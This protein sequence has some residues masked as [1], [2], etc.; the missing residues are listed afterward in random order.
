MTEQDSS[1]IKTLY[2]LNQEFYNNESIF[3]INNTIIRYKSY[4][5]D[6]DLI[7]QMKNSISFDKY[8]DL[9]KNNITYEKFKQN[10]DKNEQINIQK[11]SKINQYSNSKDL[12]QA[13][14][15]NKKFYIVTNSLFK[16]IIDIQNKPKYNFSFSFE[17]NKLLMIFNKEDKIYFLNKNNGF[18]DKSLIIKNNLEEKNC[19]NIITNNNYKKPFKNL[20][21]H[22][23]HK[24]DAMNIPTNLVKMKENAKIQIIKN[25]SPI[26][27]PKEENIKIQ[28]KKNE[29]PDTDLK[30]EIKTDIE[31]LLRLYFHLYNLNI[32]FKN[33]S[34]RMISKQICIFIKRDLIEKYK[35]FYENN[36]LENFLNSERIQKI[37]NNN[38]NNKTKF[39]YIHQ[40]KINNIILEIMPLLPEEYKCLIQKKNINEF[41]NEVDKDE[42]YNITTFKYQNPNVINIIDCFLVRIELVNLLMK[43]KNVQIKNKLNKLKFQHHIIKD[44]S[45][46][47]YK[48]TIN[49]GKLDEKFIFHSE[50]IIKYNDLE[51]FNEILNDLRN[52]T[53]NDFMNNINKTEKNI[54]KYKNSNNQLIIL[55]EQNITQNNN[56]MPINL[57]NFIT[58]NPQNKKMNKPIIPNKLPQKENKSNIK[59]LIYIMLDF[60]KLKNKIENSNKNGNAQSKFYPINIEFFEQFLKKNNLLTIYQD[61]NLNKILSNSDFNLSNEEIFKKINEGNFLDK[62]KIPL[63]IKTTVKNIYPDKKSINSEN[64]F[65]TDFILL[66]NETI[67]IIKKLNKYSEKDFENITYFFK[68][69]NI[70]MIFNKSIEICHMNEKSYIIPEYC[71]QYILFSESTNQTS[72]LKKIGYKNYIEKYTLL[73]KEDYSSPIFLNEN[74]VIGYAYDYSNF[75]KKDQ[76]DSLLKNDTL[77]AM[78]KLYFNY[79]SKKASSKQLKKGKYHL[80]NTNLIK[81]IKSD[82]NFSNLESK[83]NELEEV[84]QILDLIKTGSDF[85]ELLTNKRQYMIIKELP[86]EIIK[87]FIGKN[88]VNII[89]GFILEEI[90]ISA[91]ENANIMYYDNFELISDNIYKLLFEKKNKDY[92]SKYYLDIFSTK[93][94]T[95]FE[96]PKLVNND[97][98]KYILQIGSLNENNIFITKYILIYNSKENYEKDMNYHN[99][100]NDFDSF[101]DDFN[102]DEKNTGKIFNEQ[103]NEIGLLFNLD[104]KKVKNI[105]KSLKKTKIDFNRVKKNL[106]INNYEYIELKKE[107]KPKPNLNNFNTISDDNCNF[108]KNNFIKAFSPIHNNATNKITLQNYQNIKQEFSKPKLVG[109]QYIAE[110]PNFM[111]AILQCFCQIEYLVNYIKYKPKIK[112]IIDNYKINNRINL[113]S[114]FKI[115]VDNL[116]PSEQNGNNCGLLYNNKNYYFAPYEIKEKFALINNN[117]KNFI[118]KDLIDLILNNLHSDLNK[119]NQYKMNSQ[120]LNA[121]NK[122]QV[123]KSYFDLFKNNNCSTIS[124]NFFG[125]YQL[126]KSCS[127]CKTPQY[128]FDS[129]NSLFFDLNQIKI[130]KQQNSQYNNN[131]S[132]NLNLQDCFEY[133]R[134]IEYNTENEKNICPNCKGSNIYY[135]NRT[136]YSTPKI[137]IIA[138]NL[139]NDF[140]NKNKFDLWETFYL[141]N[142]VEIKINECFYNLR[143]IVAYNLNTYHYLAYCKSPIDNLWYKYNDD[144]V[145]LIDNNNIINEISNNSLYTSILFYQNEK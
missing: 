98:Q 42:Y 68:D 73:K 83:L 34:L 8:K 71:F 93:K 140:Q 84:K 26:T 100:K 37:I 90:D 1:N 114:S 61:Q 18:I 120:L 9:F 48:D 141:N 115:L 24:S 121:S 35:N 145:N 13:L 57:G 46:C 76:N 67:N 38:N 50:I 86:N 89:N 96:I 41:I 45:I 12:I 103:K 94:Y 29:F 133:Q 85:D 72:L 108:P 53:F 82:Y 77:I 125:I 135:K 20:A 62:F 110:A 66:S 111:N 74:R 109:L 88:K 47:V 107:Q 97:E 113:I 134:R 87:K 143:G 23:R 105:D 39:G 15:E 7:D 91:V 54:G 123:F 33:D 92:L 132:Q 104:K 69:K 144:S 21:K 102:F 106:N 64:Y 112:N 10:M 95:Y 6:S 137:L 65:Y 17:N 3:K 36:Y 11:I 99:T 129:F 40:E 44:K 118:P 22:I 124:D 32:I 101:L 116:W 128:D 52:N 138:L 117:F 30:E 55:E 5:I 60:Y 58:H 78:L 16:K 25:E 14:N 70:Y 130:Y 59:L 119:Q 28:I 63:R 31:F 80:V 27:K 81:Q 126:C 56:K 127:S 19:N 139:V 51:S 136:I 79:F 122:E 142:Y 4:L 131:F 2:D 75:N 43:Y 49:I